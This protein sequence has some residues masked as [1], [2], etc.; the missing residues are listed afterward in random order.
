MRG[1]F[2]VWRIFGKHLTSPT[3]IPKT[4]IGGTPTEEPKSVSFSSGVISLRKLGLQ[5]LQDHGTS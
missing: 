1:G 2:S 3:N 4:I 5:G